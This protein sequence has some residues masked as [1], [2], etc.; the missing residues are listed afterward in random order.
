M[1]KYIGWISNIQGV[2]FF[3]LFDELGFRLDK[4][5]GDIF[6]NF[7]FDKYN[8]NNFIFWSGIIDFRDFKD[9]KEEIKEFRCFF[10]IKSKGKKD[11]KFLYGKFF[12]I[13][14]NEI[15]K[16]ENNKKIIL[17]LLN[18]VNNK[19]CNYKEYIKHIRNL[20][21]NL[22]EFNVVILKNGLI[23]LSAKYDLNKSEYNI[24]L[25]IFLIIKSFFHRDR[26]HQQ[27]NEHINLIYKKTNLKDNLKHIIYSIQ[28]YISE[29][30]KI[31]NNYISIK[32]LIGVSHY[33]K[34][35]LIISKQYLKNDKNYINKKLSE[36]D[37]LKSSLEAEKPESSFFNFIF[38]AGLT[39][40]SSVGVYFI[41]KIQS[42]PS[43]KKPEIVSDFMQYSVTFFI[44]LLIIF[45]MYDWL[46]NKGTPYSSLNNPI[47]FLLKLSKR[48]YKKLIL[49]SN[50]LTGK[51]IL[52]KS[53]IPHIR[54][55]IRKFTLNTD[56]I[57]NKFL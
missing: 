1:S 39:S 20:Q 15:I 51:N 16:E 55:L 34:E 9:T 56:K 54:R 21:V 38:S 33:L 2:L 29:E 53:F 23:Q 10:I 32:N 43:S 22:Y 46:K 11:N 3:H 44:F 30:R 40:I 26:F 24:F 13:P 41:L 5:I 19:E 17:T 45:S 4:T 27:K 48:V 36:I 25:N 18:Q 50:P 49:F 42:T 7:N 6:F 12:F 28:R 57:I 35:L 52:T 47:S 37:N 14:E 8:E 31:N